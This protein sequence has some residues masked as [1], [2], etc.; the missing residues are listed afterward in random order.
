MSSKFSRRELLRKTSVSLLGG[1]FLL[2]SA[3]EQALADAIETGH[4]RLPER[5]D[6][7]TP[8]PNG[9]IK[10][11]QI[12]RLILG[13]N[14]IGG[15]AHARD[16]LYVSRLFKA[17]NTPERIMETFRIAENHGINTVLV[18]PGEIP[19]VTRYNREF[20]G[21]LQSMVQIWP[22]EKDPFGEID[23]AFD[24]GAETMYIQGAAAD[25]LVK[26]GKMDLLAELVERIQLT[27]CPGGV[28]GHALTVVEECE[29]LGVAKDYYVKTF[30]PDQ[31]WSAHPVEKREEFEVDAARHAEHDKFH[32][33]IFDLYPDRT[34]AFMKSVKK[35]WV[36]FKT[37]A[38]GAVHPREGFP[39]AFD[40][41][42][43]F[44][45]AG[46]FDFQVQEDVGYALKALAGAKARERS[47]MA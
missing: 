9:K 17:Y 23:K 4:T 6:P 19:F 25:R 38:A 39:F 22:D 42:A 45:A 26:G 24:L 5:R 3:E 1:S 37:M 2:A 7:E 10:D 21:H 44:V 31:Y 34:M 29:R 11:L 35:P 40:N 28:G 13:G 27:G 30:H 12:S 43:D 32:D 20:G 47:W 15:W 41:G 14:L 16:L 46:M 36:A 8:M 33:N 18:T